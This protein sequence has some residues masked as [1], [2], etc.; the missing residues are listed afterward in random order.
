[1]LAFAPDNRV[2]FFSRIRNARAAAGL[3]DYSVRK[4]AINQRNYGY[5]AKKK[6]MQKLFCIRKQILL[7]RVDPIQFWIVITLFS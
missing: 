7:N 3:D 2:H 1:M 5:D 4:A 6:K